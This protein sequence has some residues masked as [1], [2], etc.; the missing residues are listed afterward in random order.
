[1]SAITGFDGK[2]VPVHPKAKSAFGLPVVPSLRDLPEPVDLAFILTRVPA[3]ESV[4]DDMLA[5]GIKNA[6]VLAS[7]Y[8]EVGEEGKALEE[9]LVRRAIAH[10][11]TI[12]GPNCLG[13]LNAHNPAAPYALHV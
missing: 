4:L 8:R 12:L 1:S 2:L 6:V 5:A 9:S 13:F 10:D 3:V 11:I 7:G